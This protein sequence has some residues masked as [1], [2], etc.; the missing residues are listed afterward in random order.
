MARKSGKGEPL[1]LQMAIKLR[2][3]ELGMS[4]DTIHARIP[5]GPEGEEIVSVSQLYRYWAGQSDMTG[6]KIDA[7]LLALG[8]RVEAG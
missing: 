3:A 2:A 1:P 4:V 6:Q 7:V 8:L 5:P